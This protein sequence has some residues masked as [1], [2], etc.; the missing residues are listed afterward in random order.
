MKT[1]SVTVAP[2]TVEQF[3]APSEEEGVRRELLDGEVI[4]MAWAGQPHDAPMPDVSAVLQERLQPGH[5]G[6]IPICPDIAIEVVSSE[7]AK[8]LRAKV[9]L[10]LQHGTRAVGGV[11]GAAGHSGPHPSGGVGADRGRTA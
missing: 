10:Y 7:P 4:P 11:P 8:V 2:L 6:L 3:L 1:V 5:T 9:Q